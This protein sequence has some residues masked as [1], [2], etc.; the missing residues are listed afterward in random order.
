MYETILHC[1]NCGYECR[2]VADEVVAERDQLQRRNAQLERALT[3]IR[4]TNPMD[5]ALAANYAKEALVERES[6]PL[7]QSGGRAAIPPF[8][9]MRAVGGTVAFD[10]GV[11][12]ELDPGQDVCPTCGGRGWHTAGGNDPM[13]CGRCQL[14]DLEQQPH[15][16][17]DDADCGDGDT[18][19]QEPPR[20]FIEPH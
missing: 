20:P 2:L 7:A 16:T 13:E 17:D 19:Q 4:D 11:Q 9:S 12:D 15:R 18:Q 8:V 14:R 10:G 6:S 3:K 1:P 5:H